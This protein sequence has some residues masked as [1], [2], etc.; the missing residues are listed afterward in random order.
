M[1]VCDVKGLFLVFQVLHQWKGGNMGIYKPW[2]YIKLS[3]L[4]RLIAES[5]L[6]TQR[7]KKES[8]CP[9]ERHILVMGTG[10]SSRSL[11]LSN[12][13]D[14]Y[15]NDL[16]RKWLPFSRRSLG[17]IINPCS[18]VIPANFSLSS[19][20]ELES[21]CSRTIGFHLPCF[22]NILPGDNV[23]Q[24]LQAEALGDPLY[25]VRIKG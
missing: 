19:E 14:I 13:R 23:A 2:V 25:N 8:N 6:N 20:M 3:C 9:P 24:R 10:L 7:R 18:N 21:F 12:S 5:F 22:V 15:P 4:S 17:N 16:N 1:H 11:W